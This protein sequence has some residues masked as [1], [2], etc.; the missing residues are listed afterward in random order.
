M[1]N[2]IDKTDR[3][4]SIQIKY[5]PMHFF[6]P[7]YEFISDKIYDKEIKIFDRIYQYLLAESL[8]NWFVKISL[9]DDWIKDI[10]KDSNEIDTSSFEYKNMLT[11]RV[12]KY[13][14][15]Y[16]DR[17]KWNW[18]KFYLHDGIFV[19]LDNSIFNKD[20]K[21]CVFLWKELIKERTKSSVLDVLSSLG[22]TVKDKTNRIAAIF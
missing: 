13:N 3:D 12:D 19:L 5:R 11:E 16:I 7:N 4:N 8:K 22:N 15:D 18:Y 21:E 10:L 1:G 20:I 6:W 2:V 17:F 9:A 14:E